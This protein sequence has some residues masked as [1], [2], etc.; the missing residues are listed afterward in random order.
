MCGANRGGFASSFELRPVVTECR[1]RQFPRAAVPIQEPGVGAHISSWLLMA[2]C[3]R[4]DEARE[5]SRCRCRWVVSLPLPAPSRTKAAA[6]IRD[7][8]LDKARPRDPRA[9]AGR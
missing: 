7:I 9:R 4:E 6:G 5:S 2:S 8:G 3:H 1:D